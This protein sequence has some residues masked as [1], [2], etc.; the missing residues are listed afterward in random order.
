MNKQNMEHMFINMRMMH[1]EKMLLICLSAIREDEEEILF[2]SAGRCVDGLK[3]K[4]NPTHL[5]WQL[6]PLPD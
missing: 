2:I 5:D 4:T 1:K 6:L 3:K